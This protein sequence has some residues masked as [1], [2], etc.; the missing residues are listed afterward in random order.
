MRVRERE[1]EERERSGSRLSKGKGKWGQSGTTD[2]V[3]EKTGHMKRR[4][5]GGAA[6]ARGGGRRAE[7]A[8]AR[9]GGR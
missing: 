6:M 3:C 2:E 4:W 8:R 1:G 7:A 9:G 5:R